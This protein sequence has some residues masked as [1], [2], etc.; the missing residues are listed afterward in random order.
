MIWGRALQSSRSIPPQAP[1]WQVRRTR[2]ASLTLASISLVDAS[3]RA[4]WTRPV[5]DLASVEHERD[6]TA[7]GG[8]RGGA[9]AAAAAAAQDAARQA[10]APGGDDAQRA[11]RQPHGLGGGGAAAGRAHRHALP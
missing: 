3:E 4:C 11:Q 5:V 6:R 7:G 9:G 8:D 1:T 2:D 10:G